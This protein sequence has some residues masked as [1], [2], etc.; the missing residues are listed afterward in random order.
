[1]PTSNYVSGTLTAAQVTAIIGALA[2][3]RTNLPFLRNLDPEDRRS[4]P[5][6]GPKTQPFVT[7]VF[8]A[9]KANPATL[10]ASFD[11]PGYEADL[12]LWQAL[13]PIATQLTQL[14]E[15]FDDT[16][17]ALGSDLYSESLDAYTYL[18]A[19]NGASGLDELR[20]TMGKRFMKRSAKTAETP[21][22]ATA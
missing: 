9:A 20:S 5:K 6:M 19:G 11:L 21:V 7:Q 8:L 14:A 1:M 2:T 16:M 12:A 22:P 17:I 15:L 18:K 3:I 10:P 13:G 4:L